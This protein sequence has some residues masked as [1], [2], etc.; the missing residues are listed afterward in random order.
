MSANGLI[1][2][3]SPNKCKSWFKYSGGIETIAT[4]GHFMDLP[5]NDMGIDFKDYKH[6]F[7]IQKKD[8]YNNLKRKAKGKIVYLAADED[9]EGK[10]IAYMTYLTV[11]DVAEEIY[12][13]GTNE[14]TSAGVKKA[15]DN[16]VRIDN[17]NKNF[18]YAFLGRRLSD[19]LCGY[20]LS[21]M[22]N[23]TLNSGL[24]KADR[25]AFSVGRV[26]TV[27]VKLVYDREMEI[28]DFKPTNYYSLSAF[29]DI[30][31]KDVELRHENDKFDSIDDVN[32][33]INNIQGFPARINS[34]EKRNAQS[35]TIAPY[36]TSTLQQDASSK[37][38]FG[39]D[40]TMKLA[41]KLFEGGHI[42]YH[43]T[44]QCKLNDEF[45]K[46]IRDFIAQ[47]HGAD[48]LPASMVNHG[49]KNSQADAHEGVRPTNL[50]F[51]SSQLSGDEKALYDL[52]H[53]R[54]VASQMASPVFK[55][56]TVE[57]VI[58]DEKFYIKTKMCESTGYL[59]VYKLAI[60]KDEVILPEL[61]EGDE[62]AVNKL[63][64]NTHQT[65]PPKRYTQ[66]SLV[67]KLEDE[68]IGRPSTY[69]SILGTVLNRGYVKEEGEKKIKPLV[70]TNT[71]ENLIDWAKNENLAS[72]ILDYH[73]TTYLEEELDKVEKGVRQYKDLLR[74]VHEKMGFKEFEAKKKN[75]I[76]KTCYCCGG[77]LVD[78][79]AAIMCENY[80]YNRD[81]GVSEDCQFMVFK[82][83]LGI[84]KD[85]LDNLLNG[86]VFKVQTKNGMVDYIIDK[87][88]LNSCKNGK[89]LKKGESL[90]GIKKNFIEGLSCPCCEGKIALS[91]SGKQYVCE[92]T[93]T[94]HQN[95]KFKDIGSCKF[96]VNKKN[97]YVG[98]E[99][100]NDSFA[101]F[102][103]DGEL[104]LDNGKKILLDLDNEYF[105]V[106]AEYLEKQKNIKI[107]GEKC[108]KCGDDIIDI[109][110]TFACS[111]N[112][113]KS[114]KFFLIKENSY[115]NYSIDL[116]MLKRI[117]SKEEIDIGNGKT[118]KLDLDEKF[119]TK[120][121]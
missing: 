15:L 89:K 54:T 12:I 17:F 24:D 22:A 4:M 60:K 87:K 77:R 94:V 1:T 35:K 118:L 84:N 41:Q 28:R 65:K 116:P 115:F 46:D 76:D 67:K 74:E 113:K 105:I 44:D 100:N 55:V 34:I 32:S 104:I 78:T 83:P 69:A 90:I 75:Y 98:Y 25:K 3:E 111:K 10:A 114:C 39:V 6:K 79:E 88:L 8:V 40:K 43:R 85:N 73:F 110:K 26:Q 86:D 121:Y 119:F 106:D 109:G 62:F 7:A 16:K 50:N 108:P 49:S 38:G 30:E 51:D 29:V 58:K 59:D 66:A 71:G 53:S 23:N 93:K 48:K 19:R 9:R 37:L 112:K 97:D 80:K 14:I 70:L 13:I 72:W 5:K 42:T 18:Y 52:I 56:T 82:T 27:G 20:L 2:V 63:L 31:N 117:V 95:G 68:G 11:K 61:S 92:N 102:L 33:I 36:T 91:A 64:S 120:I 101:S 99:L 81:K 107:T 47:N 103:R 21:P 57:F 96:K 45:N